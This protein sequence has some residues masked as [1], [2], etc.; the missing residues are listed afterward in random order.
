MSARGEAEPVRVVI[1]DDHAMFRGGIKEMLS[2]ADDIEV[3]GEAGDGEKAVAVVAEQAPDVI[4]LDVEM[5]VVGAEEAMGR[6]LEVSQPPKVVIVTM[7]DEPRLVRRLIGRG[8][9]AYLLKSATLEELISAVRNAAASPRSPDE[10]EDVLVIPRSVL[11]NL[12]EEADG[13]SRREVEI[14]LQVVRGMSNRQIAASLYL[15][16][17]TVKRH[18]ANIYSK[19]QV[20]SRSELSHMALSEGWVSPYEAFKGEE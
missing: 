12:D 16:E 19:T 8:A 13:L 18:L 14:L 11:E 1:A 10:N 3:V 15:S 5:P 6:M 9:S 4:L 7:H 20:N 17:A 2:T